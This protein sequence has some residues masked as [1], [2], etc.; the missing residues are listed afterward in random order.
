MEISEAEMISVT[1]LASQPSA[2]SSFSRL[3][4]AWK[5]EKRMGISE[6][7]RSRV[8]DYAFPGKMLSRSELSCLKTGTAKKQTRE[9]D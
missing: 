2:F 4:K 1:S 8:R 5:K 7:Q 9:T 6:K 3:R